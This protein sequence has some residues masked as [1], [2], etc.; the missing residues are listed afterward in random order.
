MKKIASLLVCLS[1][2]LALA[3]CACAL[4]GENYALFSSSSNVDIPINEHIGG[5]A[6]GDGKVTLVDAIALLRATVGD[7]YNTSR[8]GLDANEDGI[9]S[10][11]DVVEVVRYILGDNVNLGSLV[12]AK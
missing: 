1:L 8:D 11:L 12:P 5:D 6:N 10:V 4:N 2:V 3:I 7:T 9:V